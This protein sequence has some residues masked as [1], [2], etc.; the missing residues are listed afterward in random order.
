M[1][2]T[3]GWCPTRADFFSL[4]STL[5]FVIARLSS[6]TPHF[7]LIKFTASCLLFFSAYSY[8]ILQ[9]QVQLIT[10]RLSVS[11]SVCLIISLSLFLLDYYFISH[12]INA[13][14][15]GVETQ[16]LT[17][18][19]PFSPSFPSKSPSAPH[20][21]PQASG[22]KQDPHPEMAGFFSSLWTNAHTITYS[23]VCLRAWV[24]LSFVF[25]DD[26]VYIY[27]YAPCNPLFCVLLCCAVLPGES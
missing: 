2:S 11:L 15:C 22:Q 10:L 23:G 3:G 1:I 13:R 27:L 14:P 25:Q 7:L 6:K 19:L 26:C 18:L 12:R 9:Q 21:N 24:V 4:L 16:S 8:W 17:L 20:P 5:L